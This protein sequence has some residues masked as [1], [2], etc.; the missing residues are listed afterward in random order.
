MLRYFIWTFSI[1]SGTSYW[2]L[3]KGFLSVTPCDP[4]GLGQT[5]NPS[6]PLSHSILD[7]CTP[8]KLKLIFFACKIPIQSKNITAQ[9]QLLCQFWCQ[10]SPPE[11]S[12]DRSQ[13]QHPI[14]AWTISAGAW[15]KE[16][17]IREI[18]DQHLPPHGNCF[19]C[20]EDQILPGWDFSSKLICNKGNWI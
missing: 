6:I 9:N 7:L 10:Q 13:H 15:D 3:W 17:A 1:I 12:W 11:G 19:N 2:R 8:S 18:S 20:L 5:S 14:S 4:S 16:I